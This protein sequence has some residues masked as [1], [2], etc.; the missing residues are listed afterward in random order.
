MEVLIAPWRATLRRSRVAVKTTDVLPLATP[1]VAL[2][3]LAWF[4]QVN[5]HYGYGWLSDLVAFGN[6]SFGANASCIVLP[7]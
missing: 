7:G 5:P 2:M 3:H 6:T 1:S 4:W